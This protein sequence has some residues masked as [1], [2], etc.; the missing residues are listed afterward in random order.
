MENIKTYIPEWL[1]A[2]DPQLVLAVGAGLLLLIVVFLIRGIVRAFSSKKVNHQGLMVQSFQLAPLGRDAFVKIQNL[3][4]S[5]VLLSVNT[6]N[7]TNVTVKNQVAGQEIISN[8]TYSI[9]LEA[10][11]NERINK[12]LNMIVLFAD[13]DKNRYE[14]VFQLQNLETIS[15]RHQR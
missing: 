12:Q 4:T 10:S 6:S 3:G 9:L 7:P 8:G 15:L 5:V 13:Q 14:Q 1:E 11:G 2:Y